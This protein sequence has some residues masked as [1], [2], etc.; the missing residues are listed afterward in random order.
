MT[1]ATEG[2]V[3][4]VDDDAMV[5]QVTALLL[6]KAGYEVVQATNGREAV[7]RVTEQADALD[8]VLLDVMMPVMTGHE[9]FPRMRAAAPRLPIVFFS[10]FDQSEVAEH[11]V[12]P[13]AHTA[14]LPKPYTDTDLYDAIAQAVASRRA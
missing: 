10:G 12:D 1:T 2:T 6:R 7:E 11:L 9:A 14:F 8:V 4:V 3:L 13:T 5:R